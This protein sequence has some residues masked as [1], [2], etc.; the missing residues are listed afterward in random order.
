MTDTDRIQTIE[1]RLNELKKANAEAK[2][3]GAAVAAR[4]EEIKD[5][6]RELR[7]LTP[8]GEHREPT[9]DDEALVSAVVTQAIDE[10]WPTYSVKWN[11]A[12]LS[13]IKQAKKPLERALKSIA[14]NTCCDRCQEAALVAQAALKETEE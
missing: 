4:H 11:K 8:T 1:Q 7:R 12:I 3:W 9:P 10:R 14:A 13:V 2:S 6:E 5:L